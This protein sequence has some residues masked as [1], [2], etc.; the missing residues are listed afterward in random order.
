MPDPSHLLNMLLTAVWGRKHSLP[1]IQKSCAEEEETQHRTPWL[2][3]MLSAVL[4]R[5]GSKAWGTQL[6]LQPV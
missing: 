4:V 2:K 6:G 3:A 1:Q 5:M